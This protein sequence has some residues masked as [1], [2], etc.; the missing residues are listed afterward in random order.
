MSDRDY[1][2]VVEESLTP[3][4]TEVMGSNSIVLEIGSDTLIGNQNPAEIITIIESGPQ[5]APG[6]ATL[7]TAVAGSRFTILWDGVAWPN[8][9]P[10]A[11]TDIYFDLIGGDD[12]VADPD[13]MI[14]GDA[15][16]VVV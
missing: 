6:Q 4:Y 9:R 11:R 14:D 10:S 2:V 3:S 5:G 16:E 8:T 15:R 7:E 12:T 1:I 13:W